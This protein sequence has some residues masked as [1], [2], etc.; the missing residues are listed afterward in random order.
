MNGHH[1]LELLADYGQ[2][3]IVDP[4]HATGEGPAWTSEEVEAML[5]LGPGIVAFGT[6][7]SMETPVRV[8]LHAERP[9]VDPDQWDQIAECFIS[10]PSRRIL[11]KGPTEYDPDAFALDLPSSCMAVRILWTGLDSIGEDGLEGDDRYVVQLWP[12]E[13]R[14]ASYPKKRRNA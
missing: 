7:R 12:G 1:E 2:I 13:P 11:V 3:H 10:S 9:G 14:P 5:A 6:A 4:D 8:E